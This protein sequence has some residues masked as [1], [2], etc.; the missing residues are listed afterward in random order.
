MKNED[1]PIILCLKINDGHVQPLAWS[2]TEI[3]KKA[4]RRETYKFQKDRDV[5]GYKT[6]PWHRLYDT[7]SNMKS[8]LPE[9]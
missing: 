1:F 3:S 4:A 8:E 2:N 9:F 7:I 6:S 5:V